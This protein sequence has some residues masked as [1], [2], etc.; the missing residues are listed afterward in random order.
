LLAY[1]KSAYRHT[2]LVNLKTGKTLKGVF[3]SRRKPLIVLKEAVLIEGKNM[4]PAADGEVLID[5]SNIDYIQVLP[6]GES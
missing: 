5:E 2:V 1:Q 3:W 6:T 4:S